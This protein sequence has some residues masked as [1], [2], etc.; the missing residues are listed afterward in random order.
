[1]VNHIKSNEKNDHYYLPKFSKILIDGPVSSPVFNA[2][3]KENVIFV[4]F[5]AGV[6]PFLSFLDEIIFQ[7]NVKY[8]NIS[9]NLL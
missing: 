4:G 7:T 6:A 1:M 8:K 2:K 9:K 5:G 3:F